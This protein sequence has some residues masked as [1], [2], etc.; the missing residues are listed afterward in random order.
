M[1]PGSWS[2]KYWVPA[3]LGRR[4][5]HTFVSVL[6][7]STVLHSIELGYLQRWIS[8]NNIFHP[9]CTI[10]PRRVQPRR[11]KCKWTSKYFYCLRTSVVQRHFARQIP[12]IP[13]NLGL[14][15]TDTPS[16]VFTKPSWNGGPDLELVFSDE[17]NTPG[18]T[19]WPG[20]DPYWEAVNLHYWVT[21][22]TLP[23]LW[24]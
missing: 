6:G 14:I 1:G 21:Y 15:D 3:G 8:N 10:K 5:Y 23:M 7:Y 24:C 12:K 4:A 11:N 2:S 19:F 22:L 18:R 13:G 20:D 17:F 16:N 9:D